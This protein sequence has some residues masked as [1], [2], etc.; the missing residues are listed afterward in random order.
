LQGLRGERVGLAGE[1]LRELL[2][3]Q[4]VQECGDRSVSPSADL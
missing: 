4:P 2:A 1:A 3:S